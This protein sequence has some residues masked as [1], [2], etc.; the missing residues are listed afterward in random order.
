M[1]LVVIYIIMIMHS[2]LPSYHRHVVI[3]RYVR[4]YDGTK[5][6]ITDV[7]LNNI[8]NLWWLIYCYV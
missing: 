5:Y 7:T 8:C 3:E 2:S 1:H 4:Q 6:I